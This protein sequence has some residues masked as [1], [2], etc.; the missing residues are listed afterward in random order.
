MFGS[1]EMVEE[2]H[3]RRRSKAIA[4]LLAV[5]FI[6]ASQDAGSQ[7]L[8]YRLKAEFIERFTRFIQWPESSGNS[9]PAMFTLC[10]AGP[11]PFGTY[12]ETMARQVLI[13]G[14]RLEI[15]Y[16]VSFGDMESCHAVYISQSAM[17]E[18][19]QMVH[20][21]MNKPILTIADTPGAA[22]KGVMINLYTEE[23]LLRFEINKRKVEASGLHFSSKLLK[24][25][26]I[27]DVKQE[28]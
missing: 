11:N 16:E 22:E 27:V 3:P 2:S 20:L 24:R 15:K 8:E 25:A 10:I 17:K 19:D 21:T 13:H 28:E 26:R 5:L 7:N 18:I 1:F 14:R 23:N 9:P 12:L 6:L 4:T